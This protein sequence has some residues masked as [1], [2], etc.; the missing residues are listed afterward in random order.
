[1]AS[2]VLP[3]FRLLLALYNDMDERKLTSRLLANGYTL[4]SGYATKELQK[5]NLLS[6]VIYTNRP[7]IDIQNDVLDICL[8]EHIIF[9][10]CVLL[11]YAAT[12]GMTYMGSNS[13]ANRWR[14]LLK[15]QNLMVDEAMA[16][17][18]KKESK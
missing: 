3:A 17:L 12:A 8:L 13:S 16:A 10:A 1:M 2:D 5:A 4:G 6:Y 18:A 7:V 15:E 9:H 14:Q 11:P